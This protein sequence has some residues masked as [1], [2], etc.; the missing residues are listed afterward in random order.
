MNHPQFKFKPFGRRQLIE[1]TG[2]MNLTMSTNVIQADTVAAP[3][4]ATVIESGDGEWQS[5]IFV[6]TVFKA[7][8]NVLILDGQGGEV[9]S[10]GKQLLL[11][12]EESIIGSY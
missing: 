9:V 3:L 7:G 10:H 11:V 8:D 12:N 6:P 5:G 1:I 2:K 4:L